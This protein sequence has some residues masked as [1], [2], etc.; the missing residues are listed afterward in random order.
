MSRWSYAIIREL[1]G[2]AL[3]H[4]RSCAY[5]VVKNFRACYDSAPTTSGASGWSVASLCLFTICCDGFARHRTGGL[6]P[7]V[8]RRPSSPAR[9]LRSRF[10]LAMSALPALVVKSAARA[11]CV[12]R[13][14]TVVARAAVQPGAIGASCGTG[15]ARKSISFRLGRTGMTFPRNRGLIRLYLHFG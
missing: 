14:K 12:W 6:V 2:D 15:I 7:C 10:L 11:S 4:M 13:G 9:N 5:L 1:F 8:Q 3:A